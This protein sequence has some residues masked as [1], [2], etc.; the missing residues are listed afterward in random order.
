MNESLTVVVVDGLRAQGVD[1]HRLAGNE[2]LNATFDLWRTACVVRTVPGS[3]TFI[4]HQGRAAF[5]TAFDKLHGHSHERTFFDIHAHNLGD[6]LT[7]FLHKH[8]VADMQVER[9][10]EVFV[11][12]GGTLH[13]GTRQL[14]GIHIRHRCDGTR[15]PHLISHLV[16]TRT[17][18]FCLEFIGDGP[19]WTLCRES[20][21]TLLAQGVHLQH[22]TVG[23]HRQVLALRVPVV[24]EVIDLLQG[25]HLLH[26]LR[27][28]EAPRTGNL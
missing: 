5:R 2:V 15:A 20:Q 16:Q 19:A 13:G 9:A 1:V 18:A 28:L 17:H 3:L 11:V 22:D 24:D 8:I 23:S 10:D 27:D 12:Q 14:H 26:A 6:D 21:C 25:F 7:A 4:A